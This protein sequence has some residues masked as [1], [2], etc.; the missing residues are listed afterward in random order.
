M[1]FGRIARTHIPD[2]L[3]EATR[4]Q[5]GIP[6]AQGGQLLQDALVV[7]VLQGVPDEAIRAGRG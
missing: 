4:D 5:P 7:A 2:R 6:Q 3:E 1:G